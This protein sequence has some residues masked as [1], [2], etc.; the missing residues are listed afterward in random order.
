VPRRF[1][2]RGKRKVDTQWLVYCLVHNIGT[3]Q[4]YGVRDADAR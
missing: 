3:V 4:R 1:G 2:P